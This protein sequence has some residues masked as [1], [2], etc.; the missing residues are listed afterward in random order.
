VSEIEYKIRE[1]DGS[2][3]E[4]AETIRE[5][6]KLSDSSFPDLTDDELERGFWWLAYWGKEPVAFAGM[7]ISRGSDDTA[8]FKR[9]GVL[10]GMHRGKGLQL[11]LMRVRTAKARKLG[12]KYIVSESTGTVYSAN[13]F[14]KAGFSMYNPEHPWAFKESI[15][16]IKQLV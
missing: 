16:W 14:Y 11:R 2:D 10:P 6:N 5:F 13:N 3:E 1:V 12:L 15:Y 9:A 4:V 8:Y 7:T